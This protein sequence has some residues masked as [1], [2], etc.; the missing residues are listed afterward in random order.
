ML[1][2]G[3]LLFLF[4]FA[5]S[6][7]QNPASFENVLS[8]CCVEGK[9]W[10][11]EHDTCEGIQVTVDT[12]S[13]IC[14]VAQEKCCMQA[15]NQESCQL[16]IKTARS[17]AAC[18]V[19]NHR[20]GQC[21]RDGF[22]PCCDCCALG[23][24]AFGL[25]LSCHMEILGEPCNSAYS[26]CCLKGRL[27]QTDD[28]DAGTSDDSTPLVRPSPI[29][30]V[31]SSTRQD[32]GINGRRCLV[33]ND[34]EHLCHDTPDGIECACREG[35]KLNI[36]GQSCDDI[37][38][39][40]IGTHTCQETQICFNT[41]GGF[42]CQ[43]R[44]SC[45]TGYE[46]TDTNTCNDIDECELELHDCTPNLNCVNLRGSFRCVAKVCG[47]GYITDAT[48]GCIDIDECRAGDYSC[49]PRSRC[50]NTV[51]SY[52]CRCIE[53]LVFSKEQQ[54]CEDLDECALG[55]SNCQSGT[56]C[57][58][59]N[60]SFTCLEPPTLTCTA[61]Y[62]PNHDE[63]ICVDV[64]ECETGSHTCAD[65]S[66][67]INEIGSFR[68]QDPIRCG[69]GT[70]PSSNKRSCIDINECDEDDTNRCGVGGVC[71][72][73]PGTY[74]CECSRGFRKGNISSGRETCEDIDECK[75][76]MGSH[77]K[78]QCMNTPGS[79]SCVCPHGY[80][81][82][83]YGRTCKDIDECADKTD[84]CSASET[85]FNTRGG[86]KCVA[87]ECP[88]NYA[89]LTSRRIRC[90]RESCK[91]ARDRRACSKLPKQISFHNITVLDGTKT[92]KPL[93]RMSF[94]QSFPN[95][96][97][98]FL[99]TKGNDDRAFRVTKKKNKKRQTGIVYTMRPMHGPRDYVVDL[100]LK[101]YRRRRW[102]SFVSRL[103][104]FVSEFK[105]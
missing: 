48:G 27:I 31:L 54:I 64:N 28:R 39:C 82:S 83:R 71:V 13:Q 66:T 74:R 56:T 42:N 70:R 85:C 76:A 58:N 1:L 100:T 103:Y 14:A 96:R 7:A 98:Y 89:K 92:D 65:G 20:N 43:R 80:T 52:S 46:L 79:Y 87:L 97:Y 30:P 47:E 50:V 57:I 3:Y 78:Y 101:L 8:A 24:K 21:D 63:T 49:P 18:E 93:F 77:C 26:E 91:T 35:Y 16:G 40:V 88:T 59:T 32:S 60:G 90:M 19:P 2:T 11:L 68:C 44:I 105:F 15:K 102:T 37:N 41:V 10:A 84:N 12:Y 33:A 61:G 99:L 38:E 95:D 94:V 4:G 23:L 62:Q 73:L 5:K 53:G 104:I 45:G 22:K 36:D 67:C 81:L 25:S 9:Q 6:L 69:E 55:I 29:V 86:F 17:M 72:N 34:C 51:G 75:L